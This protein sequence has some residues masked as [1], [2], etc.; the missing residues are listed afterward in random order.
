M[1]VVVRV[2]SSWFYSEKAQSLGNGD[3]I[4]IV[5]DI[6]KIEGLHSGRNSK[7]GRADGRISSHNTNKASVKIL[8][9]I[10]NL[11]IRNKDE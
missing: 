3:T 6:K 1:R 8:K 5:G 11:S 2:G 9:A 7:W 10:D 4:S